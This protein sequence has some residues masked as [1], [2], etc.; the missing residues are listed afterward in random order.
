MFGHENERGEAAIL[1]NECVVDRTGEEDSPRIIGQQL[2][3]M[4]TGEGQLMKVAEF[5]VVLDP[6][7][8]RLSLDTPRKHSAAEIHTGATALAT[9][10]WHQLG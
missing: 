3:A 6:L 5:V 7:P 9:R 10:Q 1:C 4:V 8:V 2:P